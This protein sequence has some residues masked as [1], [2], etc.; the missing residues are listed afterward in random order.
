MTLVTNLGFPRIGAKRELKHALEAYWRGESSPQQLQDI[1]KDLRH[2]H[3]RI[4]REAGAD[5]VPCN[6]FSLYDQVLDMAFLFDAIPDRYRKLADRDP[7]E[8]YFALARGAQNDEFDLRALEMTKWFDTNYH[9]LVPE[10]QSTQTFQL[11]GDKPVAEYLEAKALGLEARPV[12]LGPVSFLMLAKTVDGS[13]R[14]ALLDRLLPVYIELLGRLKA[15]GTQWVQID[16]PCLILDQDADDHAAYRRAYAAFAN[17]DRPKL[18]LTTYFGALGDNLNLAV[19]LP[20]DGLHVDLVRAP[21][22]LD[23][24]LDALPAE[25]TLSLGVVDGRNI[26]RTDL[27]RAVP[28]V[29]RAHDRLGGD[30]LQVAPSCSLLHVPVD[31]TLET[32]LPSDIQSWLSFARQKVEEVRAI[33]DALNGLVSS[34]DTLDVARERRETRSTSKRVHKPRVAERVASLE[35][36]SARRR[37]AYP[38]RR[39]L[40]EER[41]RLP[42]FPTTTIGSFPQT[43]EVREARAKHKSGKLSDAAYDAFLVAETEKCVRFQEEIGID[44]LVH[45]EFERNDMVEYF[46]EQL[47]GFAFTKNGWVQSYGSRC[48]KPPVI[49]GDVERPA[50]MTVRWSQYAQSLTDK[51]MKGMLTGPVTVLQWSFVRDDQPRAA[52]CR[53]IA[54]ALRDEVID[55]ERAGIRV[56]Q[57]DEPA[58]REGLPLRRADWQVYLDWAVE[59]FRITASGVADDT[60]IHTHM[61]YSEFNDIIDSVAA[62]D[63]DVISI[64]TSRS[65]MELLDAFVKFRY[66]NEIGPGVYDIHS[67]RVPSVD[68][69]TELLEKAGA[70][71]FPEQVWVNPDCGLKTR[72]WPETRTTLAAMV[73]AARRLRSSVEKTT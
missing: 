60:Q 1:A 54:L 24:V 6:D 68:E 26:W 4:Q 64:E 13:D 7:L 28:L 31:A 73:E 21:D 69:M 25:R 46:G 66:P 12:L 29:R 35:A 70:V 49:Y 59:C 36:S 62:M 53:Q 11:R 42:L 30:R 40:Q 22:Q 34:V 39:V 38:K 58:L 72:G 43:H 32:S 67:P 10:L 15:A 8:G 44:V 41:M 48:V 55:L 50:P 5:S 19:D 56:I 17:V 61:C 45:G 51:P 18:V 52:T 20:V 23:A 9:Y 16:E 71:L 57:I 3:W 37:S 33:V 14:L 63:A 27:D 47:D 65:R 2:R